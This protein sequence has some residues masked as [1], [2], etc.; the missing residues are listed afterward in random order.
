MITIRNAAK[1]DASDLAVIYKYYVDNFPYSFEYTAP[2]TAEFEARI[3]EITEFYPYFVCEED[4]E[5]LGFAYAH[6]YR[7]REAYK[8]ICE[9]SIYIKHDTLQRGIGTALYNELLPALK[10]QGFTKVFAGIGCPNNAS[11]RFHEKM[12][13][14]LLATFPDMGYKQD[15]WHNVKYYVYDL[16]PVTAHMESPIPFV[17]CD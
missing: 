5:I 8:W 4:G 14:K 3:A 2:D 12:G 16:N 15:S 13:F 1:S 10:M 9:T 6:K 17:F 7:E 11:E